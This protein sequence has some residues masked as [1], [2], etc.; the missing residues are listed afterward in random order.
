VAALGKQGWV[1]ALL[2][3]LGGMTPDER[4]NEGP[5]IHAA[6][7][8]VTTALA[9]RKDV[10]ESAVL[11]ARLA[12][13]TDRSVAPCARSPARFGPPCQPGDGRTCAKSSPIW[14]LPSPPGRRSR[15]TGTTSPRST[16]PRTHPARAMHDTFYF[17]DK[18]AEGR[19]MLLRTHTSPVQIRSMLSQ[20]AP[21]RII[22]PGRV[23]RS[24]SDAT[25]TPMFHQIEGLVI[26]K[27]IHLGH[28][29]WTLETFL[30]AFFEREDI[31][32]RL[33]LSYLP[34]HR[35]VSRS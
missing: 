1:S 25:H 20:G 17:P 22:A 5:K 19:D 7:E 21:V 35:A 8:A 15:T 3:S 9:A 32:L 13:E 30:K 16:C 2:K 29:K 11:E 4:S 14:A 12:A 10:L 18:D 33:R 23:Y 34:L 6:R 28:L 27:G 31:V 24:D 26:D